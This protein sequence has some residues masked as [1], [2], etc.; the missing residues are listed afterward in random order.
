MGSSNSNSGEVKN[1][2]KTKSLADVTELYLEDGQ[3]RNLSSRTMEYRTRLLGWL[4]EHADEHNWPDFKAIKELH[5]NLFLIGLKGK[6]KWDAERGDGRETISEGYYVTL[7]GRLKT[8]FNWTEE[9]EYTKKNPMALLQNPKA[10]MKIIPTISDDQ[11]RALFDVLDPSQYVQERFKFL[12]TR[13]RAALGLL[14]DTPIRKAELTGLRIRNLDFDTGEVKVMGKGRK[15]RTMAFTESTSAL[16]KEYL[17]YRKSRAHDTKELWV[18]VQG[19]AV[20]LG[21][22][23]SWLEEAGQKA[24][25]DNLHPHRFRHTWTI[26][27]I[28]DNIS[29][30]TICLIAGWSELPKTYKATL[31]QKQARAAQRQLSPV[32]RIM[33]DR[34]PSSDGVLPT[35][36]PALHWATPVLEPMLQSEVMSTGPRPKVSGPWAVVDNAVQSGPTEVDLLGELGNDDALNGYDENTVF[37]ELPEGLIDIPSATVKYKLSR[38]TLRSWV[39]RGHI[40]TFGRLKGAAPGGGYLVVN[41]SELVKHMSSTRLGDGTSAKMND[42]PPENM[43]KLWEAISNAIASGQTEDELLAALQGK[44]GQNGHSN[45]VDHDP[46]DL[47]TNDE[48]PIYDELPEGLISVP[49]AIRKYRLRPR[50]VQDWVKLGRIDLRG[51]LKAPAPRGGYLVVSEAELV[52]Y[53]KAPRNK[54]G[55]PLKA[56]KV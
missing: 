40:R 13:D 25:I 8:F 32:D 16:L 11:I 35:R 24:G 50:T 47:H 33:E 21:W 41:E 6:R 1:R 15:E 36:Q 3:A 37:L 49:L 5:V 52:A 20:G 53:M 30:E 12:S 51:R 56:H 44:L 18:D 45:G 2:R 48:L 4:V 22:V 34:L 42:V 26:R 39:T 9:H 38:A 19:K 17:D 54:G 31:G 10:A 29:T 14:V 43:D 23:R 7:H 28:E 55:R 46:L 27:A